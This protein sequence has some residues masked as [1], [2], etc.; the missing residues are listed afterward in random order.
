MDTLN[1]RVLMPAVLLGLV[2]VG[3]G[4]G[5]IASALT[6]PP[7]FQDLLVFRF[8]DVLSYMRSGLLLNAVAIA[9]F[10]AGMVGVTL[11]EWV[12]RHIPS[13]SAGPYFPASADKF[14]TLA[15]VNPEDHSAVA[16][17]V[18]APESPTGSARPAVTG[19]G[20]GLASAD[21]AGAAA[22]SVSDP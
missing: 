16:G 5:S 13:R 15:F 3:A 22:V 11:S 19:S 6:S 4:A 12:Q 8:G 2:M 9:C 7:V 17:H 14:K 18:R 1:R 20:A 21:A 10:A